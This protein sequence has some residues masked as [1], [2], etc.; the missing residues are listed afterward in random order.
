M[1]GLETALGVALA[2]LDMPLVDIVAALSWKPAAIAG[3]GDRHGLPV[4]AGN[5]ANLVVFDPEERWQ[6]RPAALA[7]RSRNTPYV[8]RDLRGRVRHTVF[9]GVAGR[10]GWGRNSMNEHTMASH[11]HAGGRRAGAGRRIRVRGRAVR[12]WCAHPRRRSSVG[13]FSIRRGRLQHGAVGLPGDPHR[14]QLRRADHHVHQPAHRELRRQPDRLRGPPAVLP[15][16]RRPRAVAPAEQP[17]VPGRPGG[18]ARALRRPGHHRHRHPPADPA[19]P[20]HRR[21]PRRHRPGRRPRRAR[22]R[23]PSPSPAPT[24]STSSPP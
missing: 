17:P 21:H 24:A 5:T 8:G 18:D 20:R 16:R 23:R 11:E 13:V 4:E 7:S 12:C 19:D 14:P 1:L 9:R 3:V 10:P 2:E 15:G 22:R 6:V